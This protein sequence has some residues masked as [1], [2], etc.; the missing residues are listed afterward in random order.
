LA[1]EVS[2]Q[3]IG[4]VFTLTFKSGNNILSRN[5]DD[6]I[7]NLR[8]LTFEKSEDFSNVCHKVN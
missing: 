3:P 6:K 2:G 7:T 4:P 5:A 1:T 8:R